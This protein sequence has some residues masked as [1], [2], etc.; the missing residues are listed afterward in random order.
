MKKVTRVVKSK[1][2]NEVPE[3]D[4]HIEQGETKGD[5][6]PTKY[7]VESTN[8]E[9]HV[10]ESKSEDLQKELNEMLGVDYASEAA[11]GDMPKQKPE[12]FKAPEELPTRKSRKKVEAPAPVITPP[13]PKIIIPGRL[14]VKLSDKVF[15][16]VITGVDA[17]FS[18]DAAIDPEYL[19]VED[20]DMDDLIKMAEHMVQSWKIE[21]HPTLFFLG[22]MLMI[23]VSNY[24][25]VKAL[26]K[27][28]KKENGLNTI[29]KP[30][31]GKSR[32]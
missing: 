4:V 2:K 30:E 5:S 27:K 11:P 26:L 19:K 6:K 32:S 10:N 1:K 12:D 18:K 31:A 13:A 25:M 8:P 20:D 23:H 9:I 22:S 7:V 14:V 15:S 21:D 24:T 17:M 3:I 16:R 28:Q 29:T